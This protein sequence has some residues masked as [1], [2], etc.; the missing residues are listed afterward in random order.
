MNKTTRIL[1]LALAAVA[2][3]C[4]SQ[5]AGVIYS[6]GFE[7]TTGALT[8]QDSW[9]SFLGGTVQVTSGVG[10]NTSQVLG[11]STSTNTAG[12]ASRT[13]SLG[14][15]AYNTGTFSVDFYRGSGGTTVHSMYAGFGSSTNASSGIAL[16]G[17]SANIEYRDGAGTGTSVLLYDAPGDSVITANGAWHR[18]TMNLNFQS[19]LITGVYIQNLTT[20]GP[21]TQLYFDSAATVA[22]KTYLVDETF[23]NTAYIRTGKSTDNLH[24]IDN[25][26]ITAIPEPATIGMLGLGALVTLLF[27]R[28]RLQ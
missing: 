27:R 19:N 13:V 2:A 20:P 4:T 22:T 17:T 28:T 12:D 15:G 5:A 24:F 16:R 25:M 23:W 18:I 11:K 26:S 7:Y 10:T 1:C 3:A 8:G 21:A 9:A 6:N 14:L